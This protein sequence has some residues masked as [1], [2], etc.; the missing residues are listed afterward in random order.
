MNH[1]TKSLIYSAILFFC[2]TMVRAQSGNFLDK[3]KLL[4]YYQSQRYME[5]AAYLQSVYKEDT[6]D[7]KEISQ[8]AYANM[9]AGN[10][11]TAEKN[12][13]KLY[14]QQP[15]SLPVLFNLASISRRRGDD[16]KAKFY[17]LEI[18]KTDS[19]N[20]NV[21]KQL[22]VMIANPA[23]QEKIS[24]LKKANAINITNPDVAFD[25][26]NSLNLTKKNDSAYTVIQ[27][28]LNADT[29][30]IM[31]LKAKL[32]VCIALKK[33]EEAIFTGD[34]LLQ[35]G[36]SS[37]YVLNNMGKAYFITKQYN[38]SLQ[39]FK[40]IER[41]EQ[42]NESTLYY[43]ALCYRELKN[44]LLATDY[45]KQTIKEGISPIM[46]NYYR[47]LGEVY[48]KNM[49]TKNARLAYYKSLDYDHNGEVYY[50]LALLNDTKLNNKKAA[51]KFYNQFLLSKPD[52]EKYKEVIP[53]VKS[54]LA[55]IK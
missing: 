23:D 16:V 4:E 34:K 35:S 5:A 18:I 14:D 33:L 50:N 55:V 40:T 36:D 42:Q 43:T 48:E 38:K 11:P 25:L 8:I 17:Y 21:Y 29:G 12:Y 49:Q 24:Y 2:N 46:S 26:A 3:E 7:Q 37:T 52:P 39:M 41:M 19:L 32:P 51:V 54:R 13:L 53:Y 47:I 44:Y 10:L 28:A 6:A 20:F 22:A 45:M 9:M 1:L 30:N 31:L 27:T 15:G